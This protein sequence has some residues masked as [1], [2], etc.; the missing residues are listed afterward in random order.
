MWVPP[1]EAPRAPLRLTADPGLDDVED[2]VGR[3]QAVIRQVVAEHE[4]DVGVAVHAD[5]PPTAVARASASIA[6]RMARWA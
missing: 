5:D 6:A 2:V 1:G 3:G 4:L